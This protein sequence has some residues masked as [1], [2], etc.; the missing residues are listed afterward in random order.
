MAEEPS[1]VDPPGPPATSAPPAAVSSPSP[2]QTEKGEREHSEKLNCNHRQDDTTEQ[3][4][5]EGIVLSDSISVVA[6][7]APLLRT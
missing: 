2:S 7:S 3:R 4:D 1:A 5:N 6:K